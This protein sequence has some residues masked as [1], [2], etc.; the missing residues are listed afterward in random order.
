MKDIIKAVY[1][2]SGKP[3][4][5]REMPN[6]L[7]AFQQAVNGYIETV[8]L[9]EDLV[10]LCNEE[11]RINAMPYNCELAGLQLF[12]PLVFVG[13]D[14]EDFGDVPEESFRYVFPRL[15]EEEKK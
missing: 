4:V 11:G 8:T 1:K 3:A 15:F 7:E 12:G 13:V 10:I 9:F 2:E 14:G 6:T 5:V